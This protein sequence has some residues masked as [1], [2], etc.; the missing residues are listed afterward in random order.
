MPRGPH[1]EQLKW[2]VLLGSYRDIIL[3]LEEVRHINHEEKR[4]TLP[5]ISGNFDSYAF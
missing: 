3:T 2:E 4:K 1:Y 5:S